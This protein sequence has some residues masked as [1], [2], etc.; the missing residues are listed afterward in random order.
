MSPAALENLSNFR[1]KR[2]LAPQARFTPFG[3]LRKAQSQTQGGCGQL[4]ARR[5]PGPSPQEA[6]GFQASVGPQRQR[7]SATRVPGS[8]GRI[9]SPLPRA[10]SSTTPSRHFFWLGMCDGGETKEQSLTQTAGA[11]RK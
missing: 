3:E 5:A 9:L 2:L 8:P 10:T 7:A 4:P 6:R 1:I 11:K